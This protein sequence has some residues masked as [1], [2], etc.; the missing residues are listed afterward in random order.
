LSRGRNELAGVYSEIVGSDLEIEAKSQPCMDG[1]RGTA[2]KIR[3]ACLDVIARV[4][5]YWLT[6]T[7]IRIGTSLYIFLDTWARPR[8][9]VPP[10]L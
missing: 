4:D 1:T 7:Y 8:F 5:K 2:E 6:D 3:N 9:P 10:S